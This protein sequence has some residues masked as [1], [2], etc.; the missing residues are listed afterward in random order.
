[1]HEIIIFAK[2]QDGKFTKKVR[3]GI[4][5]ITGTRGKE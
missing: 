3:E 5:E 4:K 2:D 1:M